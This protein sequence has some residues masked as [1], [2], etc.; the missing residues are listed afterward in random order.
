[1]IRD[2]GF[3]GVESQPSASFAAQSNRNISNRNSNI[4]YNNFNNFQKQPSFQQENSFANYNQNRSQQF[5]QQDFQRQQQQ[6]QQLNIKKPSNRQSSYNQQQEALFQQF[7]NPNDYMQQG[8]QQRTFQNQYNQQQEQEKSQN[9][10][11]QSGIQ[12]ANMHNNGS[13]NQPFQYNNNNNSIEIGEQQFQESQTNI[14][15]NNKVGESPNFKTEEYV[16]PQTVLIN[17]LSQLYTM[18]LIQ[19][20]IIISAVWFSYLLADIIQFIGQNMWIVWTSLGLV[21]SITI[22]CFVFKSS[23]SLTPLN[24]ILLV[25]QTLCL[26]ILYVYILD[27]YNV[28]LAFLILLALAAI[29]FSLLIYILTTKT[30]LNFRGSTLFVTCSAVMVYQLFLIFTDLSYLTS[31]F[32]LMGIVVWGYFLIYEYQTKVS[33]VEFERRDPVISTVTVFLDVFNLLLKVSELLRQILL[34]ERS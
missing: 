29:Y 11:Y 4:Q 16:F 8:V 22:G 15:Q 23:V 9:N 2:S 34:R 5:E 24:Y 17:F 27:K 6:D 1:M 19:T 10:F 26:V 13:N 33:D 28:S 7:Y 18:L 14:I 31:I 12:N 21:L 3:Q 20:L 25:T 30:E 32:I